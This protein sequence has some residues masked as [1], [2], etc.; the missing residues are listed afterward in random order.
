MNSGTD[1]RVKTLTVVDGRSKEA[2]Q[3]VADTSIPT[4][5]VTRMSTSVMLL[6]SAAQRVIN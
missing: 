5:Y 4:L 1:G 2:V 6:Q 3:I